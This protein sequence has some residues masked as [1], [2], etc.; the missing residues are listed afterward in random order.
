[1]PGRIFREAPPTPRKCLAL[2][3]GCRISHLHGDGF[4]HE[5]AGGMTGRVLDQPG[6][7]ACSLGIKRCYRV[8]EYWGQ[9]LSHVTQ[10]FRCCL[11]QIEDSVQA[12]IW[13]SVC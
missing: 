1:M 4:C 2:L 7:E 6:I 8:E 10:P 3:G 5:L 11:G 13:S 12:K 9:A